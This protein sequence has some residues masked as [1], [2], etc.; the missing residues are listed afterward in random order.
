VL[1]ATAVEDFPETGDPA[2]APAP[3]TA[4]G[5]ATR[6]LDPGD[7]SSYLA[8]D[9]VTA[10]WLRRQDGLIGLGTAWRLSFDSPAAA[11]RW[12][13]AL[14]AEHGAAAR[15]EAALPLEAASPPGPAPDSEAIPPAGPASL[16]EAAA[17]PSGLKACGGPAAFVSFPCDPGHTTA[18][19]EVVVPR[20]VVGR[21]GPV[22]WL[23]RWGEPRPGDPDAADSLDAHH[24]AE[25]CRIPHT[26][27]ESDSPRLAKSPAKPDVGENSDV[28]EDPDVGENPRPPAAKRTADP[29]AYLPGALSP[30]QWTAAVESALGRIQAGRLDKVVLARDSVAETAAGAPPLTAPRLA[31]RLLRLYPEAWTFAVAGLVGATPELLVR[32]DRGLVTSRVLAG[33]IRRHGGSDA[34]D[35][36]EA[37]ATSGKDLAE[38]EYAVTSVAEALAPYCSAMNVP[39]TPFVLRLPNVM[40]L[41]SD[42]TGVC[43]S[44]ASVLELA[45]A[46]HPSAA[47]CG[48]PT[49]AARALIRE[50]EGLDRGRYAGPVGWIGADGDGEIGLALRCGQL[51]EDGRRIV[52]YAGCGIVADS[53]PAAELAETE[54]KLLPMRQAL[55]G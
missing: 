30:A 47:I 7:L 40:H 44:Q 6:R 22:S 39:E 8:R 1:G 17:G 11:D 13:A 9:D 37:L 16:P 26:A 35:L 38:H 53:D 48:T 36:A 29:V 55:E 43:R 4:R 49:E 46:V 25:G 15:P 50:L 34:A 52:L 3:G 45:D 2:T 31:A 24:S 54:A 12:W 5:W 41:A 10:V 28:G 19:C 33:T 18:R 27:E 42:I 23:T 20:I 21:I 51:S 32:Q 14:I